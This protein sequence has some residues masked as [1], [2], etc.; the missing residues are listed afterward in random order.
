MNRSFLTKF[1]WI[2]LLIIV[3][4]G[5]RCPQIYVIDEEP[6]P[7]PP[8]CVPEKVRVA[9]VL[10]SGGVRGMAH[11]GVLEELE[12]A[13]IQFDL[14]IGCS[15]GSIV[16]ALY[17]DHPCAE[18]I[19]EA[20]YQIKTNSV[21]DIDLLDCRYGISQGTSMR[22][23]LD[24]YLDAR[25]FEELQIPLIVVASDLRSGELVPM[26]S[27]DLIDAVQASACIPFV[28]VP[29]ERNGRVMVDG[30]VVNPVPVCIA[31]DLGADIVIAVDLCEL[32]PKT[33][34]TNLFQ[35]ATRSSEIIFMWQNQNCTRCADV[36]IQPKMCDIGTFNDSKKWQIYE[37]GKEAGREA[38][39]KILALL[40]QHPGHCGSYQHRVMKYIPP[41]QP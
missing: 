23:V 1:I 21:I 24:T 37:A 40:E 5:C 28:F 25:C 15:A 31:K 39:P 11:V 20:V 34:P 18:H 36:I 14:I 12:K 10:G 16:G 17:A 30:G 35:V 6:P 32:L 38:V 26:G 9:L 22:K 3:L 13:G 4:S 33:F 29:I 7:L 2:Q 27:G 8:I 19:K 41:Y